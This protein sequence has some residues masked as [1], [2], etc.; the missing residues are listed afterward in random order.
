MSVN[1]A[2]AREVV[3]NKHE[4]QNRSNNSMYKESI[5]NSLVQPLCVE[6]PGMLQSKTK[7]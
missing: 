4:K 2:E 1:V 5:W 6:I 3:N 7:R